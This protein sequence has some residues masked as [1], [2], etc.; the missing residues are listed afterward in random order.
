MLDGL[1]LLHLGHV[2]RARRQHLLEQASALA[3]LFRQ[4]NEIGKELLFA[5]NQTETGHVTSSRSL[6]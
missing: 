1:D 2:G 4:A 6:S 3:E 5:G